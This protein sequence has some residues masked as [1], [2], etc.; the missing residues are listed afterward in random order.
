MPEDGL[1]LV[2][3]SLHT[4]TDEFE[5]AGFTPTPDPME[6]LS[7]RQTRNFTAWSLVLLKRGS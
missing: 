1:Y 5:Y 3:I 7:D 6:L 2:R 4:V